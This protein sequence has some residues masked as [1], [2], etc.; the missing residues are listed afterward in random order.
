MNGHYLKQKEKIENSFFLKLPALG[1][2]T[3]SL[4]LV[5]ISRKGHNLY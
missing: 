5:P 2:F 3:Q 1:K 4:L